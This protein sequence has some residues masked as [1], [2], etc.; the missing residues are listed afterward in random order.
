MK[1]LPKRTN[2]KA[3]GNIAAN[4]LSA[5]LSRFANPV[6]IP[7]S[8]DIGIDFYCELLDQQG[9]PTGQMFNIQCK[10]TQEVQQ[11]GDNFRITV[12]VSTANYWLIQPSPTFIIVVDI[13]KKTCYWAYPRKQL[14]ENTSWQR[15]KTVSIVVRASDCFGFDID[16]MPQQMQ[17]ILNANV[18]EWIY[19]LIEQFDS[20]RPVVPLDNP[21]YPGILIH[22]LS[23]LANTIDIID[24]LQRRMAVMT[25]RFQEETLQVVASLRNKS[26][27]LL[28]QLDYTPGS[29]RLWP[30][31]S[32]IDIS[33]FEFGAG[34]SKDVWQRV[35]QAISAFKNSPTRENHERLLFSLGELIQLNRDI[36]WT[37]EEVCDVY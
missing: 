20:K 1:K 37:I 9:C 24:R 22:E 34:S 7:E 30:P 28:G 27:A 8:Q 14:Q 29:A 19:I 3:V 15:Q 5:T 16:E 2:S 18:P 10:G 13:G 32:N 25:T 4:L 11:E 21:E 33:S 23:N 31:G 35:D 26:E 17:A 36:Y 6:A 12:K